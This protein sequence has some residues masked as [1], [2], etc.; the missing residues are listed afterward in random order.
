MCSSSNPQ[1]K[2]LT[3]AAS[4]ALQNMLLHILIPA[5]SLWFGQRGPQGSGL[6]FCV[7]YAWFSFYRDYCESNHCAVLLNNRAQKLLK[8]PKQRSWGW[9]HVDAHTHTHIW[10]FLSPRFGDPLV[11]TKDERT[12]RADFYLTNALILLSCPQV[13]QAPWTAITPSSCASA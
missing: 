11:F 9:S 6:Q 4:K 8:V 3:L 10:L 12:G 1:Q 2:S 7:S 13:S 5:L